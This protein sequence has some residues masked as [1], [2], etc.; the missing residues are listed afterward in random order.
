MM[1][2]KL[3][4]SVNWMV[5]LALVVQPPLAVI[6]SIQ[7]EAATAGDV[8]SNTVPEEFPLPYASL[9]QFNPNCELYPIALSAESLEGVAVGDEIADIYSGGQP[10]NFG[11]LTWA[12]DPN[13]PTLIESLTPPGD[14]DTYVNPN[15]PN[16]HEVSVG[17]WVEGK[18]GISN[19]KNVRDA[20]DELK[21][22]DIAVPVWGEADAQGNNSLYQVTAY[23]RV[24]LLDYHLPGQNWISVLFLGYTCEG[25]VID[26]DKTVDD[27]TL[28]PTLD[29]TLSVDQVD[30]IPGDELI[31]STTVANSGATLTL[32]GTFNATNMS[33]TLAT[34]AY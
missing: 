5:V 27:L 21:S 23:A 11:W 4:K 12:G 17:D 22:Y 2:S 19:T 30:A 18:P 15:D 32:S 16:D 3:V 10:G 14:S 31:Y 20:L 25:A 24:R 1:S 26:L 34:M 29:M 28:L 33:D 7:A 9:Q 6:A 8:P 13:V